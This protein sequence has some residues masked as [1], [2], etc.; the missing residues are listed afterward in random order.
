MRK[1]ILLFTLFC[2][3]SSMAD[4]LIK[5]IDIQYHVRDNGFLISFDNNFNPDLETLDGNSLPLKSNNENG[6]ISYLLSEYK[7]KLLNLSIDRDLDVCFFTLR[8]FID[9]KL[10][11]AIVQLLDDLSKSTRHFLFYRTSAEMRSFGKSNVSNYY[12]LL[13]SGNESLQFLANHPQ[14]KY[15]KERDFLIICF[16]KRELDGYNNA[17]IVPM[18]DSAANDCPIELVASTKHKSYTMGASMPICLSA[19]SKQPLKSLEY[20]VEAPQGILTDITVIAPDGNRLVMGG[21]RKIRYRSANQWIKLEQPNSL[22]EDS[23]LAEVF[24]EPNTASK[25]HGIAK[26]GTYHVSFIV[27]MSVRLA[28]S[29]KTLWEGIVAIAPFDFS[30]TNDGFDQ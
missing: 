4:V 22:L 6:Q 27:N 7:E 20:R 10:P 21:T 30:V 9:F 1:A 25:P 18:P 28:G 2:S 23:D 15:T 24:S 13:P 19:E 3:L 17:Y 26:P 8:S 5:G 11:E 12:I 29:D 14:V 16:A